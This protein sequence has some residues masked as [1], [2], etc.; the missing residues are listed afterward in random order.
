MTNNASDNLIKEEPVTADF[1]PHLGLKKDPLTMLH[2]PSDWNYCHHVRPSQTPKLKHQRAY[3]LCANYASCPVFTA[4]QGKRLPKDMRFRHRIPPKVLLIIRRVLLVAFLVGLLAIAFFNRSLIRSEVATL[5]MPAWQRTQMAAP[6]VTVTPNLMTTPTS[7]PA[8]TETVIPTQTST[9]LPTITPFR[10]RPVLRPGV[11]IGD[12]V[13]FVIYQVVEGDTLDL[14]ANRY[15]TSSAAIRA[16]TLFMPEVLWAE[17]FVVIPVDITDVSDLPIF[18]PYEVTVAQ[19]T[20]EALAEMMDIDP[21]ALVF[22]NH[23]WPGFQ[24]QQGEWVLLPY[25]RE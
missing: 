12:E 22:Y 19:I 6:P 7:L 10:P 11:P 25:D 20:V 14:I 24:L 16:S 8:P 5:M 3:C 1:C 18:D 21:E 4:P 15:N 9:P 13:T 17:L 2:Y 23:L